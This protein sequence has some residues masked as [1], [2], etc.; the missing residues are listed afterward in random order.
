MKTETK[1]TKRKQ[2]NIEMRKWDL[3]SGMC[4]RW[5][6]KKTKR[7]RCWGIGRAM[8]AE[9]SRRKDSES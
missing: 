6:H 7:W 3:F 5:R 1:K 2:Y 8:S 4:G 9:E